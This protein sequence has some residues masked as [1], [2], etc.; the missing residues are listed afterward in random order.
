[1]GGRTLGHGED[2]PVELAWLTVAF[3]WGLGA[4]AAARLARGRGYPVI[5]VSVLMGPLG[6]LAMRRLAIVPRPGPA[7]RHLLMQWALLVQEGL[8]CGDLPEG[9]EPEL[10][11][12]AEVAR[13]Q[14]RERFFGQ[15]LRALVSFERLWERV[16]PWMVLNL[17]LLG[18][19]A[20]V[21]LVAAV[22][23]LRSSAPGMGGLALLGLPLLWGL[24]RVLLRGE[25]PS[26]I[27]GLRTRGHALHLEWL[28]QLAGEPASGEP[29]AHVLEAGEELARRLRRVRR[30]G[31]WLGLLL[32]LEAT[33]LVLAAQGLG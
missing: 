1:M 11:R 2:S 8:P 23:M 14:G 32:V 31:R 17:C 24:A 30:T 18:I 7:S 6:W 22:A 3:I 33:L 9:T 19:A 29:S 25:E 5:W 4:L 21:L 28:A 10:L 12:L 16:L 20:G 13:A 26:E 15:G 27:Q